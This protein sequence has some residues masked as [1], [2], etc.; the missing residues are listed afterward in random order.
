M[1]RDAEHPWRR[2]A[3]LCHRRSGLAYVVLP[4]D[5]EQPLVLEEAAAEVFEAL[6]EPR[7]AD[8]LLT[9]LGEGSGLPEGEVRPH[10]ESALTLLADAGVITAV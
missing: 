10:L 4:A 6:D 1:A 8:D 5:H 2:A 9:A 3:G 7:T